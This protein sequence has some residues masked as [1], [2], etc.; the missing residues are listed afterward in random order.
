MYPNHL[1][2]QMAEQR[3]YALIAAAGRERAVREALG[4]RGDWADAL[5]V[6]ARRAARLVGL[7]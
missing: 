1:D 2:L 3:R 7:L 4:E 5:L 6:I